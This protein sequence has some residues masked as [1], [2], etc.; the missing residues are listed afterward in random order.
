MFPR[1]LQTAPRWNGPAVETF[2][3]AYPWKHSRM[4]PPRGQTRPDSV[5]VE[6]FGGENAI[7]DRWKHLGCRGAVENARID[8][9][10]NIWTFHVHDFRKGGSGLPAPL[11]GHPRGQ[12]GGAV[13]SPDLRRKREMT[14]S[15]IL[16]ELMGIAILAIRG[17]QLA[18][19]NFI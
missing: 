7:V 16:K 2:P 19:T 4:F 6:T 12:A 1:V 10:I 8:V 9:L 5:P 11:S 14:K 3:I 13:A 15:I 17:I 18:G